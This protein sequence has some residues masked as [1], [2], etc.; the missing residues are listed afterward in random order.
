MR[1]APDP[2]RPE[3]DI[4]PPPAM[5]ATVPDP[6]LDDS[7]YFQ[8][9]HLSVVGRMIYVLAALGLVGLV[10]TLLFRLILP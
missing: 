2:D 5:T 7:W 10:G 6:V 1:D 8:W 4:P 3:L 9:I